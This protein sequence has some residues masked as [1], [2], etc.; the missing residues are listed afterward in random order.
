MS[1]IITAM[2]SD[3]QEAV[4]YFEM[5][6]HNNGPDAMVHFGPVARMEMLRQY[7]LARTALAALR[8]PVPDPGTGLIPCGCGA[9]AVVIP[10][11]D[12]LFFVACD[13]GCVNTDNHASEDKAITAWNR[14]MG[15]SASRPDSADKEIMKRPN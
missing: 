3:L 12:D 5:V 2:G 15:L 7:K 11:A 14:A 8:G 6:E 4:E 1:Y 13:A 10:Y 9:P